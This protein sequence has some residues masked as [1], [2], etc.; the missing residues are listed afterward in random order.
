MVMSV[1]SVQAGFQAS[2]ACSKDFNACGLSS[3]PEFALACATG[4]DYMCELFDFLAQSSVCS[5]ADAGCSICLTAGHGDNNVFFRPCAF[6]IEAYELRKADFELRGAFLKSCLR[7]QSGVRHL[8]K[9]DQ[10]G[11]SAIETIVVSDESEPAKE[12]P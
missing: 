4:E 2:I 7:T 1:A 12:A 5:V 3:N 8:S 10:I 6:R 11:L 9:L